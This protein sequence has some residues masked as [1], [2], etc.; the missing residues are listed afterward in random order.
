MRN[1]LLQR[2]QCQPAALDHLLYNF[3]EEEVRSRP[4]PDK[5]NIFENL[6]H[7]AR[8]H[9]IFRER[10]ILITA[11][12]N[13]LFEAYKADNDDGFYEWQKKPYK[14]LLEDFYRDR[15]ALNDQ[16][17]SLSQNEIL[18]T[19]RHP[20]YGSMNVEGWTEFFLLHEAHHL[21]TIFKLAAKLQPGRVMGLY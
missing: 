8:Y 5:W 10:I 18:S 4:L 2:L 15:N 11:G 16:L 21:F 19:G 1:T 17:A 12:G 14:Q 7:L 13:P 6:S 9:E 20:V 3:S